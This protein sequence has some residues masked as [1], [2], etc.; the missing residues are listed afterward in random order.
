M[1]SPRTYEVY[2]VRLR[3][4]RPLPLPSGQGSGPLAGDIALCDRPARLLAEASREGRGPSAGD[5]WFRHVRLPDGSDYVRWSGLFEF[6]VSADG[7]RIACHPL[8]G[9]S[10]E[11][12]HTYL[13]GQAL[14]FA[15]L[16]QGIEPLHAT[17][18]VIDGKA[19]GFVGDCGYGKSSLAA[20]FLQA[21][22]ALLTDDLLVVRERRG[23]FVAYPG[24]PRVKLY[25]HIAKRLLSGRVTGTPMN[26][27]TPKLVIPL[28]EEGN[29]Y[30]REPSPLKAIY[31]LD[32][33]PRHPQK[34]RTTIRPFS[35]R[36]AFVELVRSTF[37]PLVVDPPRLRR[38]F[39]LAAL[40]AREIPVRSLSFPRR[41]ARLPAVREAI[42]ADLR[43]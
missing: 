27:L 13:L 7:R 28:A 34:E 19:V 30:C 42:L 32:A 40:L 33:P 23:A 16:K 43:A 3:S 31:V 15:L 35:P 9:T 39:D 18:V 41:L 38:Q 26:P 14:S 25:P 20:A 21:G 24:P 11:A 12:F 22:H 17:A 6:L 5:G 2:G 36:R 37:N 10:R 4:R 1:P 8:N 29:G